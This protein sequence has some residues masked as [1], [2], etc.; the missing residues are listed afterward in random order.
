[1]MVAVQNTSSEGLPGSIWQW[2]N[3]G[4][5]SKLDSAPS[6]YWSGIASSGDGSVLVA[7]QDMDESGMPGSLYISTDS[8]RNFT[9]DKVL[10]T[11]HWAG[12]S[13][14]ADGAIIMATQGQ[15]S[16]RGIFTGTLRPEPPL[17]LMVAAA[18]VTGVAAGVTVGMSL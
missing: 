10:A 14:S 8:G 1:M 13:V 16:S 18:A 9:K 7:I 15:N 17:G 3:G 2:V 12:V 5:W 6:G 4:E 11:A